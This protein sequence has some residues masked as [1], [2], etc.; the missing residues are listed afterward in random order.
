[1]PRTDGGTAEVVES[2]PSFGGDNDL[3]DSLGCLGYYWWF[4]R[5][6]SLEDGL[7][8]P[9]APPDAFMGMGYGGRFCFVLM[10]ELDMEIVWVDIARGENWSPFDEVGRFRVNELLGRILQAQTVPES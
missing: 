4:N 8:L 1:M 2:I 9:A 5:E 6:T 7:L 3:K 10:P